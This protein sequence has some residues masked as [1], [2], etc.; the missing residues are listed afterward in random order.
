MV[1]G[2]E[3]FIAVVILSMLLIIFTGALLPLNPF[4]GNS[5]LSAVYVTTVLIAVPLAFVTTFIV[6]PAGQWSWQ[7]GLFRSVLRV[8]SNSISTF[9]F[10]FAAFASHDFYQLWPFRISVAVEHSSLLNREFLWFIVFLGLWHGIKSLVVSILE[11]GRKT[12]PETLAPPFPS[13]S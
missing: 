13:H 6:L 7:R 8:D 2:V 5:H 9:A 4:H 10:A 1:R 11:M 3:L 12:P